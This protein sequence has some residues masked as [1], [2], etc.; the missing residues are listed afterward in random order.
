MTNRPT[1]NFIGYKNK[2]PYANWPGDA[3]V[4]VNFCINYE[5]GAEMCILNGDERSEVR[6][7]DLVVDARYGERDLNIE[8][9]YEYGA[10]VGYWRLLEAFTSRGLKATVNLVGLA[11]ELNPYALQDMLDADFDLQPHGWRWIDY[12]ELDE[13][14]ERDHIKKSIDQVISLTGK[15]PLGYYAGL[16][17]IHTRKLVIEAESFLYDSDSYADDLP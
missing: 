6:V 15:P 12:H 16:P 2:P 8:S 11:G 7:S 5:E 4:A 3:R 10:R 13:E 9:N 14:Q 17:S 1:R